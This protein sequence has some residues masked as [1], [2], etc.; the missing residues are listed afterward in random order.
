[1]KCVSEITKFLRRFFHIFAAQIP[2]FFVQGREPREDQRGDGESLPLSI[3]S[4][5][6]GALSSK[7]VDFTSKSS[8]KI[9]ISKIPKGF[10]PK[11]QAIQ[12]TKIW[13][14]CKTYKDVDFNLPEWVSTHEQVIW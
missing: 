12:A 5:K 14:S 6:I 7:N 1:M 2:P 9:G 11:K 4:M 13:I 3:G 8:T 10:Q